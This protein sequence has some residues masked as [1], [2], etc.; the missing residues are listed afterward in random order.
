MEVNDIVILKYSS[1][2]HEDISFCKYISWTFV[3]NILLISFILI[4]MLSNEV[5]EV[6]EPMEEGGEG[7]NGWSAGEK[8]LLQWAN[9]RRANLH[10]VVAHAHLK[11]LCFGPSY[12]E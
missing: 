7:S 4:Q 12:C 1:A 6:Q 9:G 5:P 3:T 10:V 11:L 2:Q 8:M